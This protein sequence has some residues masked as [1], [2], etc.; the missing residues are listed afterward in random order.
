M[1]EVCLR[2]RIPIQGLIGWELLRKGVIVAR[3]SPKPNLIV[4]AGLEALGA[5][6]DDLAML[7]AYAGV[8]TNNT[9]PNAAQTQLISPIGT[10]VNTAGVGGDPPTYGTGPANAYVYRRITRLFEEANANG[11]LTEVGFFRDVA[12]GPMLNRQLLLDDLGAPTAI[13]KTDEH[14]LRVTLEKRIYRPV[15]D[16]EVD[17]VVIGGASYDTATRQIAQ[18]SG[19]QF[20]LGRWLAT[21]C[22]AYESN[23]L[24]VFGGVPGGFGV[25]CNSG[26]LVPYVGGSHEQAAEWTWEPAA[27][28]F[29]T[30]VGMINWALPAG[31]TFGVSSLWVTN[32]TPK[33]P[34]TSLHR[35]ELSAKLAWARL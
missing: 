12:G 34:K 29:T 19:Y 23:T 26:V 1:S 10:R 16:S 20:Q 28:N 2:G 7:S 8:G 33:I 24:P 35:L 22:F 15:A 9:A 31:G 21:T 4:N 30:G 32:F 5:G 17:G 13:V 6:T 14:Q 18:S 25:A 3:S 27:A 11:T